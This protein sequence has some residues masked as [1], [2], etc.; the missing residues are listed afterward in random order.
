MRITDATALLRR[1]EQL[2]ARRSVIEE[3]WRQCFA[4][5]FPLRG[6]GFETMGQIPSDPTQQN[7]SRSARRRACVTTAATRTKSPHG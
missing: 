6:V 7:A 4:Y 1:F 5:T 2:K 3:D